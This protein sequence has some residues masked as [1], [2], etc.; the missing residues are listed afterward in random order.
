[1]AAPHW[2]L[3]VFAYSVNSGDAAMVYVPFESREECVAAQ[4]DV[5]QGSSWVG[6]G[7]AP[8]VSSACIQVSRDE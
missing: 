5:A 4:A 1:M 2:I 6:D 8:F 3:L 7:F